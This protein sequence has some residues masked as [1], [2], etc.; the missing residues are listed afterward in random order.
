MLT[1]DISPSNALETQNIR[2]ALREYLVSSTGHRLRKG[3]EESEVGTII[4][5]SVRRA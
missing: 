3:P 2:M 4:V 5:T 1:A